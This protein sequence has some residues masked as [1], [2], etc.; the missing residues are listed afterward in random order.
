MFPDPLNCFTVP[1]PPS[2]GWGSPPPPCSN[3]KRIHFQLFTELVLWE[4][5]VSKSQCP[6]VVCLCVCAIIE[7]LLLVYWRLLVKEHIANMCIPLDIFGI[8]YFQRFLAFDIFSA[9][10]L[11]VNQSYVHNLELSK[12][13]GLWLWLLAL[14][15]SDRWQVTRNTSHITWDTWHLKHDTWYLETFQIWIFSPFCLLTSRDSVSPV[16][17]S[18]YMREFREKV[19]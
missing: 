13:K 10:W 16:C 7:N 15:T 19:Y 2:G 8:L 9:F 4:G 1:P 11:F 17:G 6:W 3:I 14:V 18:F 12:G 5:S